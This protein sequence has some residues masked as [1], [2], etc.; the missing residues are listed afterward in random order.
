MSLKVYNLSHTF[1]QFIPEWP[2]TPSV[3]V[4]VSKF[5]AKDGVY[6]VE[7]EGIM[8][9]CTHMDAPLHVTENTPSIGDYPLWRLVGTG[10]CV[11]IPKEK[12][13]VITPEDLENATP[14]IQ[15]GDIVMIN[16]GFHRLWADTDEYFAYGCGMG[17]DGARWLVDKK[18]KMVG[19]GHQANDHPI[20]TKLVDH[21]LGP[22]TAAPHR[23]VQG[24]HRARRQGRLPELGAGAQDPH[25]RGRHPRHRER[26]RRPRRG[27]RQALH[28][29]RAAVA[30]ARRR[31]L[32]G[33]HPRR[34]RPR[35]DLQIREWEVT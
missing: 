34:H 22:S 14:A 17:A 31:R 15:E 13:G 24:V 8:H 35:P 11:D 27:H 2:S 32:H 28:L 21:G 4:K 16:T 26:R 9:R 29:P 33:A 20:A 12:W 19:Y 7:W 23:R 6:E 18:V 5:H 30:L 10:V 1:T 25:V 3:N